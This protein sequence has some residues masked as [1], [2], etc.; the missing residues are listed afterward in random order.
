MTILDRYVLTKFLIP[1]LYCFVGF[2]AIWFIFDLADNLQDFME[3]KAG[4][5]VI[6]AY[7]RSQIPEIIVM[8]IPVGMLLALLYSL[9][10]MSRSNELISMLGAGRSVMRILLPLF[11]VS[12]LLTGITLFFN[13]ADAPHAAAMRKQMLRDIKRGEKRDQSLSGHLFRNR[14]DNRT[15]YMRK[16]WLGDG[17]LTQV[18]IIQQ[19][20]KGD[21]TEEWLA[22]LAEYDEQT[23][24]WKLTAARHIA[25]PQ[26][27]KMNISGQAPSIEIEG[28]SET[29]WRIS[30][31]VMKP[32]Y[33]SVRELNDYLTYNSDFPE[34]RLAPY[35]THLHYRFAL[36]LACVLVVM[37]AA[38]MGI[39][40]SRRG[41]LAG[42][43]LAVALFFSLV[44]ISSLFIALGKGDRISPVF[45][46]W[47]PIV[48]FFFV[49]VYL[50]WMRSTNRDLPKIPGF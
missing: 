35:R 25:D 10:A 39:V 21:I 19:N 2:L 38:P 28:W 12:F 15:W 20:E 34:Q 47:S 9:T 29:P 16:L 30:S 5:D 23:K 50:L 37:L 7:Y 14:E 22:N 45:A 48:F 43:A 36:P 41:I 6:L 32:D 46:A 3:G 44:F 33:L 31:S 4:M 27:V 49:G 1:F 24:K 40:Y 13:Y 18:Q 17:R 26:K 11:A 8:S 42:V